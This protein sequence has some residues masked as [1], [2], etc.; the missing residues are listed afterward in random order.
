MKVLLHGSYFG[1]NFGD[2]L[3]CAIFNHWIREA[4]ANAVTVPLANGENRRLIGADANGVLA[5]MGAKLIVF[6]GGGYFSEPPNGDWRWPIRNY[7]RHL[8]L[9]RTA[10]VLG[11]PYVVYGV[12][13]GPLSASWFRDGT[14][15]LF[16]NAKQVIVRDEESA[17]FLRAS[18]CN[19]DL[20]IAAD[21]AI[22]IARHPIPDASAAYARDALAPLGGRPAMLIHMSSVPSEREIKV[23]RAALSW[24]EQRP[25][26]GVLITNDS[27]PRVMR[28][29]WMQKLLDETPAIRDRSAIHIYDGQPINLVALLRASDAV[30]TTKLHVGIVSNA[31]H[32]FV[33]SVPW[34][35][36]TPRFYKQI[37]L[38]ERCIPMEGDW[39]SR[40]AK[41][42]GAWRAGEEA[43]WTQLDQLAAALPY[44]TAIK[45]Q[46]AALAR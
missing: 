30:V 21:A 42:L 32:R 6:C 35:T 25:E 23:A 40:V 5:S 7:F 38:T 17:K 44:E 2:T 18:G 29:N 27:K 33:V 11:I 8:A 43:D 46:V 20:G 1:F 31:L 24:A 19:A 16:N 41:R 45:A 14:I 36:K 28:V 10:D 37:G 22:S 3:L 34:H 13:A 39:Q 12:G 15:R 9:A 4:G 26:V